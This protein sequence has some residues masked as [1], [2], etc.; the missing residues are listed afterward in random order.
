MMKRTQSI[1]V[2]AIVLCAV[3]AAAL[4][5]PPATTPQTYCTALGKA[6]DRYIASDH[7][8][9]HLAVQAYG[10]EACKEHDA[11]DAVPVL[12]QRLGASKLPLPSHPASV[13]L[14][15]PDRSRSGSS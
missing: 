7:G 4:A 14:S 9:N 6:V 3:P 10:K 11:G 13:A 2:V 15:P 12:E 5:S 8:A 1:R